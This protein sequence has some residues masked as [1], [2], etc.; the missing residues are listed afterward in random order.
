MLRVATAILAL[1]HSASLAAGADGEHAKDAEIRML[2]QS[3][4]NQAA[5]VKPL[6]DRIDALRKEVADE[7]QAAAVRSSALKKEADGLRAEIAK[8]KAELDKTKV[9]L[10]KWAPS[11]PK[12]GADGATEVTADRIQ[13][14]GEQYE[15]KPVRML[16]CE[17]YEVTDTY[18][19]SLPGVTIASNGLI[20]RIDVREQEKW[21]GFTVSDKQEKN[22]YF[23][24]A[25]KADWAEYLLAL[26][27][28]D[29]VNLKGVV[30]KLDATD[31]GIVCTGIERARRIPG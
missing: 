14:M 26:K 21:V 17:F 9:E 5:A 1:L 15:N 28:G 12:I 11:A 22:F 23:L 20:S 18:I 30:V 4:K 7:K 13:T 19:T 2:R 25:L 29:K 31:H 6:R 24:Y 8:L 27:R 10:A 3:A 16:D